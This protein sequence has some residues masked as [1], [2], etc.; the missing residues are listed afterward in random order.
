MWA[1]L[2]RV[3]LALL[4]WLFVLQSKRP[5]DVRSKPAPHQTWFG[6]P[7]FRVVQPVG[8][9]GQIR[10]VVWHRYLQVEHARISRGLYTRVPRTQVYARSPGGC[11]RK[12]CTPLPHDVHL[13]RPGAE[14]AAQEHEPCVSRTRASRTCCCTPDE[15]VLQGGVA[16]RW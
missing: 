3:S 2:P 10:F 8:V 15:Y 16:S 1:L 7:V 12:L 13:S 5:T 9:R 4:C 6:R 14:D 11:F